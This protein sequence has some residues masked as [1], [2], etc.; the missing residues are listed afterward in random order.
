M[1]KYPQDFGGASLLSTPQ[2]LYNLFPNRGGGMYGQAPSSGAGA[3]GDGGWWI[4]SPFTWSP[5][6]WWKPVRRRLENCHLLYLHTT[7]KKTKLM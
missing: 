3:G 2:F 6:G 7:L 4:W 1:F 5:M